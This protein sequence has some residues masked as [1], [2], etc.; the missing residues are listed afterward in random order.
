MTTAA[1]QASTAPISLP[2]IS[3]IDFHTQVAH[4]PEPEVVQPLPPPPPAQQRV[5]PPL[6]YPYAVRPAPA[7]GPPPPGPP[8]Y[9]Q[10]RPIYPGIPSPYQQMPGRMPLPSTTDPNLIVAPPRHK[11]K[12]VKRRTKTGCLTC[13]KRRIKFRFCSCQRHVFAHVVDT[14][15]VGGFWQRA[16]GMARPAPKAR[17]ILGGAG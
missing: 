6:P 17:T 8:E 16:H 2:P 12:E 7:P 11:A 3:S 9:V 5:L 10:S 15:G 1:L 14:H 4:R 13:R